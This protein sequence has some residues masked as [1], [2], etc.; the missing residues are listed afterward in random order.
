MALTYLLRHPNR[1]DRAACLAGYLPANLDKAINSRSL[2]GKDV[3]IA[4]GSFDEIVPIEKAHLAVTVLESAGAD[5]R[6]CQDEVGHKLGSD[7]YKGLEAF[8]SISG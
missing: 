3:F 5:I 2:L 7:C 4:H 1:I 8:F 6:F